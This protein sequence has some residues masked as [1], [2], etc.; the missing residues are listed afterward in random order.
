VRYRSLEFIEFLS[1]V[2]KQY[3]EDWLI[4]IVLGNRSSHLSKET[5]VY[6]VSVVLV[7]FLAP[8]L[9]KFLQQFLPL[10]GGVLA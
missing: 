3:P 1:E 7:L 4:R 9:R 10:L 5:Q 2:D 8:S 6:L